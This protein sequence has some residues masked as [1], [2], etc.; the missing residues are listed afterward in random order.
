MDLQLENRVIVCTGALG[1]IGAPTARVLAAEGARLLLVDRDVDA[2]TALADDL[3][4]DDHAVFAGDLRDPDVPELLAEHCVATLG[5]L[6]GLAHLA[7]VMV[8]CAFDDLDVE[9]WDLHHEINVRGSFLLARAAAGRMTPD[10]G[11]RIVLASSGAWLSG[12]LPDR[13]HY[14]TTK[15]AV[16]TMVR[17]LARTLGPR[18][19]AVNGI[20]P[21]MV[22]S[23]M[24][25]SGLAPDGQ[26]ELERQTPLGR[27]AQPREI[28]DV[29]A[30]LL[31]S[32]ASFVSGSTVAVSGGLVLH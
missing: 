21:G 28:A 30:F 22:D 31:S 5:A 7:A 11:G 23:P 27:F 26:S 16:T 29:I 6:D 17:G 1:G 9:T 24:M 20:A 13:L 19:V 14:A 10:Q 18:G 2:L 15:G 32:R 25:H 3:D 8:P 4:G 12:G